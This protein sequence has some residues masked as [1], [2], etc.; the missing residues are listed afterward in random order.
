MEGNIVIL[1]FRDDF[2]SFVDIISF[3]LD[4]SG[5][6]TQVTSFPLNLFLQLPLITPPPSADD[7]DDDDD[8]TVHVKRYTNCMLAAC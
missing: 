8:G 3:V 7:D 2:I 4:D 5:L 1:Q 6:F